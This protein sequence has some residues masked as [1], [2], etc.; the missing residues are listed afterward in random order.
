MID[1]SKATWKGNLHIAGCLFVYPASK[2]INEDI[3]F[4]VPF[5]TFL[6]LF[7]LF[8]KLPNEETFNLRAHISHVQNHSRLRY[9][10]EAHADNPR[11]TWHT[12][13]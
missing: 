5:S 8:S 1:P 3:V 11:N 13:E 7:K 9:I 2:N 6:Y 4:H 12:E 10:Q